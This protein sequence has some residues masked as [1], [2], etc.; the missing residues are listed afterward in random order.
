MADNQTRVLRFATYLSPSI[1]VEYYET[2]I[3]YV[4]SQLNISTTLMY[5]S[6]WDGPPKDR[7]DPFTTNDVDIAFINGPAYLDLIDSKNKYAKLLPITAVHTH[8]KSEGQPVYFSDIIVHQNLREQVKE[9]LDLRGCQ[10]AYSRTSSL[11][12]Y[13]VTIQNLKQLGENPSF[14]GNLL[15][16][17]SHINSIEMVLHKQAD[18]AAVDSSCLAIYTARHPEIKNEI[19]QLLSWGPLPS[20]PIVVNTRLPDEIQSRIVTALLNMHQYPSWKNQLEEFQV[21][22]FTKN[23]PFCY[24]T[25]RDIIKNSKSLTL[26]PIYY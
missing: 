10:W 4:E 2:I 25:E 5:E 3:R 8:P 7:P 26:N 16:S 22:H 9:F 15:P 12:G 20:L 18:A 14:F 21:S 1:P 6:R 19:Y 11:S 24:E 13:L 17:G 23:D